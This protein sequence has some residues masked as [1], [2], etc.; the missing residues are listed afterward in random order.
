LGRGGGLTPAFNFGGGLAAGVP[1]DFGCDDF[2][3]KSGIC[4]DDFFMEPP[5]RDACS[6]TSLT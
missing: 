4:R 1:A 6:L 2:R 3:E 5:E